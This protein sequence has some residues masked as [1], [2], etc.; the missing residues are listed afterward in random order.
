MLKYRNIVTELNKGVGYIHWQ[1]TLLSKTS[2]KHEQI[3]QYE[4]HKADTIQQSSQ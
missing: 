2:Y 3:H 4:K 1:R